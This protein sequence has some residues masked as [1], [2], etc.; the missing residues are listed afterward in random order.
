[1]S[2]LVGLAYCFFPVLTCLLVP[3]NGWLK[4][5]CL[6]ISGLATCIGLAV[7]RFEHKYLLVGATILLSFYPF[8]YLFVLWMN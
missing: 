7:S 5:E 1:M 3:G 2:P 8:M 4:F 6:V